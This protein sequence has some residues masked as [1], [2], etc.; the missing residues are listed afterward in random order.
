MH[1]EEVIEQLKAADVELVLSL[2]CDKNKRFT[3]MVHNEIR[4]VDLAKEEDGVGIAAGAFMAGTRSV[5]SIQSSGLGN[6]M[7]AI[8]SLTDCYHLPLAVLTSWRGV[9]DEKIEAQCHFNKPIPEM[10][11]VFGIDCV[12]VS[13]AEDIPLIGEGIDKAYRENRMTVFLIHP[14]MWEQSDRLAVEY[15]DRAHRIEMSVKADVPAPSVSR[16][17]AI[18]A[19]MEAVDDDTVVVSNIGV[20]SKEVYASKDRPLNF[21]MMGSFGQATPIGLG[22]ALCGKRKVVVIDGDGSLLTDNILPVVAAEHPDNLLIVCLDNGTFGSTGHQINHAY[23]V[24]DMGCFA[25][26]C[27]MTGVV[28]TADID[29]AKRLVKDKDTRFLQF[30]ILPGNSKSPNISM[31][32]TEVRD[33]FMGAF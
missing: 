17:D 29:E 2:P 31:S 26:G 15:P 6:M 8:M 27:G 16:L 25:T 1:E 12:D 7:N 18:A 22:L 3:D 20:P 10:L 11:N 5:I 13:T 28:R 21:Y 14:K 32:A 4:T 19:I 23:S 9:D 24:L 33:R 30:H